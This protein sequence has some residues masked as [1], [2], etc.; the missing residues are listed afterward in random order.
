M[1]AIDQLLE[2]MT[3]RGLERVVLTGDQ[4]MRAFAN[5]RETQAAVIPLARLQALTQEITPVDL[6]LQLTENCKLEFPYQSPH[7]VYK[8]TAASSPDT[9]QVEITAAVQPVTKKANPI[10]PSPN[11][12]KVSPSTPSVSRAPSNAT[13]NSADVGTCPKCGQKNSKLAQKCHE[14]RTDLPWSN[15]VQEALQMAEYSEKLARQSKLPQK[16]SRK[17]DMGSFA[18]GFCLVVFV[19][20]PLLG[21]IIG[22]VIYFNL[23]KSEP[24]KA[25][26]LMSGMVAAVIIPII[27]VILILNM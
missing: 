18:K 27:L 26:S 12:P 19:P 8:I 2:K 10:Q 13:Q 14:C 25:S 24:D 1:A 3:Q 20:P 17:S 15:A 4:P 22:G 11:A 16:A 5:G 21:L 9:F 23:R 7:G 6:R